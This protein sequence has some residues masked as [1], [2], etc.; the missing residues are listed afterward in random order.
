MVIANLCPPTPKPVRLCFHTRFKADLHASSPSE[1]CLPSV[2]SLA[3]KLPGKVP[4]NVA[5]KSPLTLCQSLV[6]ASF[7]APFVEDSRLSLRFSLVPNDGVFIMFFP[8]AASLLL[9]T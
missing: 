5:P 2:G 4:R 6:E 8:G 3:A 1:I 7:L 9:P